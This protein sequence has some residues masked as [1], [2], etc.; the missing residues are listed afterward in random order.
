M[1]RKI[2]NKII[3]ILVI[4]LMFTL[5]GCKREKLTNQLVESVNNNNMYEVDDLLKN[6]KNKMDINIQDEDGKSLLMKSIINESTQITY[7]LIDAGI[8]LNLQDKEGRTALMYAFLNGAN[9]GN[10]GTQIIEYMIRKGAD[11][12]LKD[13]K[14]NTA[15]IYSCR[16][17]SVMISERVQYLIDNGADINVKNNEGKTTLM[18][19]AYNEQLSTFTDK[20]G[21]EYLLKVGAD[22][23]TKDNEGC[24]YKYY[25]ILAHKKY[26]KSLIPSSPEIGM[27]ATEVINSTWGKPKEIN[28]TTTKDRVQEQWVYSLKRYI[29]LENGIVTTIQE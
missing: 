1:N 14:G 23:N 12:N 22:E 19:A 4:V 10:P 18:Y 15:L 5:V 27:T 11:V 29:Y 21:V 7:S 13:N 25:Q 9:T 3:G 6:N 17:G 24:N 16:S 26:E 8:E 28:K 20:G 2:L